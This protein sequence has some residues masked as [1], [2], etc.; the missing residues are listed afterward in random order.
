MRILIDHDRCMGHG[1]CEIV[2]AELFRLDEQGMVH[3]LIEDPTEELRARA[4]LAARRC[5]E[6]VIKVLDDE[7]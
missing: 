6:A 1:Q 2:A 7:P 4:E 3:L 5:P